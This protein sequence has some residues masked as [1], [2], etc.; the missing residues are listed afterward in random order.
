MPN[1]HP[2]GRNCKSNSLFVCFCC[3]CSLMQWFVHFLIRA[4]G[5]KLQ[6]CA[7]DSA[8]F[9]S[10]FTLYILHVGLLWPFTCGFGQDWPL[11]ENKQQC[12]WCEKRLCFVPF[13]LVLTENKTGVEVFTGP[14]CWTW[15]RIQR[16]WNPFQKGE[17]RS[18][19]TRAQPDLTRINPSIMEPIQNAVGRNRVNTNICSSMMHFQW[20]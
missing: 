14:K 6:T 16:A 13:F 4:G 20:I 19:V 3:C 12:V 2:S 8:G 1:L 15:T 9:L 17:T 7:V 11:A 18:E 10:I 5:D